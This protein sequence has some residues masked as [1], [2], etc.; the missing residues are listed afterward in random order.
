MLTDLQAFF[1]DYFEALHTQD[2]ALF[3]RVF[4]PAATL[5]SRQDGA[6]VVRPLAEYREIV[7]NRASPASLAQPR[8]ESVLMIDMLSDAMAVARVRLRLFDNIMEDHLNIIRVDDGW[9]II[10]KTFT[11]VGPV[12]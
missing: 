9:R 8:S 5:Y 6:T 11:R 2:L 1:S 4:D 7:R 3:D 12:Q 10:A